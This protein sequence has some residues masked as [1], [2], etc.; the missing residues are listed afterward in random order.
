MPTVSHHSLD[1]NDSPAAERP[2]LSKRVIHLALAAAIVA[3]AFLRLSWL[4]DIE[5]KED[6]ELYF[7]A[8]HRAVLNGQYA[9]HGMPSS[10]NV[11][12]PGLS[13]W[14]LYPLGYL[15]G[16]E[17]PTRLALGMAVLNILSIGLL[18]VFVYRCV[19]PPHRETWLW[20]IALA[21]LNPHCIMMGRKIWPVCILPIFVIGFITC[22]WK[23]HQFGGAFGWGF[24]SSILGQI[25]PGAFFYATAVAIAT[26]IHNRKTVRWRAWILGGMLG[27]CSMIP[28]LVYLVERPD[29]PRD[30]VFQIHRAVMMRYWLYWS[31]EPFGIGLQHYLKTELADFL[32]GPTLNGSPTFVNG[33]A[34]AS[35][36]AIAFVLMLLALKRWLLEITYRKAAFAFRN[37][38]TD[39]LM[40]SVLFGYGIILC[41][42]LMPVHRHYLIV[43]FP[44]TFLWVARLALPRGATLSIARR[45]RAALSILCLSSLL[46]SAQLLLFIH[47]HRGAPGT[48]GKTYGL[49]VEEQGTRIPEHGPALSAPQPK[50]T[51]PF[52]IP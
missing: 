22:W 24:L 23:R 41:I 4:D 13:V 51:L 35:C 45:G 7:G 36:F 9:L 44:L 37:S 30:D 29:S 8:V 17:D 28:W 2:F 47:E 32:S 20:A 25:H 6:E 12:A 16:V 5:Y 43:T 18:L 3:G 26:F 39:I 27:A 10:Q 48:Y 11:R 33:L 34:Y 52:S 15:F 19:E 1:E 50:R 14:V 40:Q 21:S 42:S 49:L 46:L 38:S 31:S